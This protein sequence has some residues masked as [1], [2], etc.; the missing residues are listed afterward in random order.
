M[1]AIAASDVSDAV[2]FV[3]RI[4]ADASHKSDAA[5][6]APKTSGLE[7]SSLLAAPAVHP[8]MPLA[9]TQR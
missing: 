8:P 3:G 6:A 7:G 5:G 9:V 4:S 1:R 2:I